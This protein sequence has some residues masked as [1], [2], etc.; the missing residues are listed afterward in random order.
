MDESVHYIHNALVRETGLIQSFPFPCQ[1]ELEMRV[2]VLEYSPDRRNQELFRAG[3]SVNDF[4]KLWDMASRETAPSEVWDYSYNTADRKTKTRV[5]YDRY[6]TVVSCICKSWI[7]DVKLIRCLGNYDVR[8]NLCREL[9]AALPTGGRPYIRHKQR[10]SMPVCD[11]RW[12]LDITRVCTKD[13]TDQYEVELEAC[14][15]SQFVADSNLLLSDVHVCLSTLQHYFTK[16][17]E[18]TYNSYEYPTE[19]YVP[20]LYVPAQPGTPPSEQQIWD[21]YTYCKQHIWMDDSQT[22]DIP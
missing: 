21:L 1:T 4:N 10:L 12:R 17:Q 16:Q 7:E 9:E 5:S 19:P 11:Q 14:D 18:Y 20:K 22:Q 13:G 8:L 3:V 6:R 15:A 2:G